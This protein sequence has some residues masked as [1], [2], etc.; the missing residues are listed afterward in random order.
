MH[1]FN[2]SGDEETDRIIKDRSTEDSGS[3][4]S[5]DADTFCDGGVETCGGS[6]GQRLSVVV[7]VMEDWAFPVSLTNLLLVQMGAWKQGART[8]RRTAC[9]DAIIDI[10]DRGGE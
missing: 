3:L 1:G 10:G 9:I 8:G 4:A 2:K 7:A 5:G 6:D